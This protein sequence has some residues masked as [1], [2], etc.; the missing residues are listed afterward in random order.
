MPSVKKLEHFKSLL[1]S[2]I[3]VTE[4]T[5]AEAEQ[6]IRAI[7]ARQADVGDQAAAEYERQALA[8]KAEA[9]RQSLRQLSHALER[10]RQGI[11]GECAEC[12][13]DIEP[14]RLEA[15]PWARYCLNCQEFREHR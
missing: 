4:R 13:K 7:S 6:E 8:H 1:Q 9:A 15:I 3:A 10:I 14:K 11:F 2:R 5:I 12:G